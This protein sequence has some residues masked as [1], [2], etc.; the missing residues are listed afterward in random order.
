MHYVVWGLYTIKKNWE[1]F[2]CWF[3]HLN[4]LLQIKEFML[5]FSD[6]L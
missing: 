6:K 5:K 4:M 2:A 1:Q 3:N